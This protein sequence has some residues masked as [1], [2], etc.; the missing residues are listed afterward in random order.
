MVKEIIVLQEGGILLFHYS[1]GGTKK[2]DELVAAFLSA[3]DSLAQQVGRDRITTISFAANKLVWEKKGNLF[4][5]AM[6]SEESTNEIF[7]IILRDLAEQFVSMYY[8]DLMNEFFDLGRFKS[9][10]DVVETTLH[11]FD[12]I[13]GLARRYKTILLPSEELNILAKKLVEVEVSR[14]VLRGCLITSDGYIALSHLRAYEIEIV[15]DLMPILLR[16]VEIREHASLE[17]PTA[18]LLIRT[19]NKG[20]AAF[21]V[22]LGLSE[23]SYYELV[24]PF[25]AYASEADFEGARKL[26]PEKT[27]SQIS[28]YS[29]D[30]VKPIA[31][32]DGIEHELNSL[33]SAAS[34]NTRSGAIKLREAL[35]ESPLVAEIQQILA[36]P[37][38]QLDE[39]LA[40]LI[41]RNM[42]RIM[43]VFPTLDERDERFSMF[44]EV[45]GI[46]KKDFDVV[47]TI[48]KYCD[49]S[50]SIQEISERT[51]IPA[52]R[53]ME[54]L[55]ELG[56]NVTW[57]N[58]RRLIHV[59]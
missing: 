23:E 12:G 29:F 48:W 17:K 8:A 7:R 4:F 20:V 30:R 25:L 57:S 43:K 5:I 59:R 49:G 14:D 19:H 32:I 38:N 9:F 44:L 42:I 3:V 18:L 26:E 58:D 41:A 1:I 22:R 35:P 27:E 46:K 21:I 39:L 37:K 31:S 16:D 6:I 11:K 56:N 53:I 40:N 24:T 13:P 45:I 15:L 50:L 55:R 2:L 33:L 34:E 51:S 10:T 52:P 54:V 36:L 47:N 28:F